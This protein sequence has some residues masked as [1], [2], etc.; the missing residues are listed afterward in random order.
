MSV[1]AWQGLLRPGV[2][3]KHTRLAGQELVSGYVNA[4]GA[5]RAEGKRFVSL[6]L[7]AVVVHEWFPVCLEVLGGVSGSP[8]FYT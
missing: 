8:V 1:I 4:I 2:F 3:H 6:R 5:A 7:I